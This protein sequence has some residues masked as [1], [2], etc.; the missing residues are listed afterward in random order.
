VTNGELRWLTREVER[1]ALERWDAAPAGDPL[2][3]EL[4]AFQALAN[5]AREALAAGRFVEDDLA[6]RLRAR[7][8]AVL[9][10]CPISPSGAMSP[11]GRAP[12]LGGP[13]PDEGWTQR[14]SRTG[15]VRG[16]AHDP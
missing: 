4:D 16:G 1:L 7:A 8:R 14:P 10:R 11:S 13:A 15:T 3:L 12:G 5:Q 6:D 2:E 9:D